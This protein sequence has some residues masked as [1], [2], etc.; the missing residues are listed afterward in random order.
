MEEPKGRECVICG[1]KIYGL[2]DRDLKYK[3]LMHSIK[4]R[5][6]QDKEV[7]DDRRGKKRS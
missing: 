1:V 5:E 3:L 6:E 2:T 7:E 4:H